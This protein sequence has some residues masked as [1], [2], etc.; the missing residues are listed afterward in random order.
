MRIDELKDKIVKLGQ[1]YDESLV[2]SKHKRFDNGEYIN[3]LVDYFGAQYTVA[4]I[5]LDKQYCFSTIEE[6]FDEQ[7]EDLQEE[8]FNI[9]VEFVRTPIAEREE[10][11]RYNYKLKAKY[12]WIPEKNMRIW[13]YLNVKR[14]EDGEEYILLTACNN[15]PD[16]KCKFT[17]KEIE[18][19][20]KEFDVDLSI[21]DKIEVE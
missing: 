20:V 6:V 16:Y 5:D 1:K 18:K 10:V 7:P 14:D 13:H 21:F 3:F 12:S 8:L 19:V 17:D 11:K 9:L 4:R 2:I 15:E